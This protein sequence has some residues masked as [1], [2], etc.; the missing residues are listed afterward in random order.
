MTTSDGDG[1]AG[2]KAR[3]AEHA[4]LLPRLEIVG[5]QDLFLRQ[6]REDLA[7]GIE[8]RLEEDVSAVGRRHPDFVRPHE[9]VAQ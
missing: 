2:A 1:F 5:V 7:G 9:R 4:P 3:P 6:D 8:R